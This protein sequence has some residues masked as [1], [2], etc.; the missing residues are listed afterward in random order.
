MFNWSDIRILLQVARA[1]TLA[2]AASTLELDTSTVSRRLRALEQQLGTRLFERQTGGLRLT[3]T[4]EHVLRHAEDMDRAAQEIER[5]TRCEVSRVG[6]VVRVATTRT[7]AREVLYPAAAALAERHPGL[8]LEIDENVQRI[9]VMRGQADLALTCYGDD[10]PRLVRRKVFT[11]TA[12]LYASRDYLAAHPPIVG[13][14][15]DGHKILGVAQVNLETGVDRWYA[16]HVEGGEVVLRS[17][18]VEELTR[19]CAAGHGVAL[20][21]HFRARALPELVALPGFPPFRLAHHLVVHPDANTLD[22][23]GAV[24]DAILARIRAIKPLLEGGEVPAPRVAA[25]ART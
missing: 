13:K 7:M 10:H 19:L 8:V 3:A 6:G 4:G 9:D 22:R 12:G 15:L 25:R 1:D 20:L 11:A 21:F 18:S 2:E 14:R 23:V 16:D 24:K 5:A 17:S